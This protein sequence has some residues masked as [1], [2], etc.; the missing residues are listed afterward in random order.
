MKDS[1]PWERRS[2]L[3]ESYHCPQL[4]TWGDHPECTG[5]RWLQGEQ[6]S[7]WV[8]EKELRFWGEPSHWSSQ[9]RVLERRELHGESAFQKVPLEYW[10]S[11]SV[12][13]WKCH[14]RLKKKKRKRLGKELQVRSKRT[15]DLCK[16]GTISCSTSQDKTLQYSGHQSAQEGISSVV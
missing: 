3:G 13:I 2:K 9:S 6:W 8:E 16:S 1:D 15:P 12:W 4:T 7:R 11:I 10:V 14:S 5:K